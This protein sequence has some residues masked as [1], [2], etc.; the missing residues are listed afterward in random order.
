MASELLGPG[1]LHPAHPC[2]SL[3][4]PPL[5]H[6][7]LISFIW[8]FSPEAANIHLCQSKC[9]KSLHEHMKTNRRNRQH[10]MLLEVWPYFPLY[11]I[12][13]HQALNIWARACLQSHLWNICKIYY[14]FLEKMPY[15]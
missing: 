11:L 8:P 15:L 12:V 2:A 9:P 4:S 1:K 6:A 7:V 13:S 5:P 10:A 3:P 14:A